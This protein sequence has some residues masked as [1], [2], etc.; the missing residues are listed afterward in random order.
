MNWERI[1]NLA[2]TDFGEQQDIFMHAI[3]SLVLKE[4]FIIHTENIVTKETT[5]NKKCRSYFNATKNISAVKLWSQWIHFFLSGLLEENQN[6][7][8]KERQ[9]SKYRRQPTSTIR[10]CISPTWKVISEATKGKGTAGNQ[11]IRLISYRKCQL[12]EHDDIECPCRKACNHSPWCDS[13]CRKNKRQSDVSMIHSI[14]IFTINGR[15]GYMKSKVMCSKLL[16][17]VGISP[18]LCH[19]LPNFLSYNL[20]LLE[21]D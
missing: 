2:R 19:S 15:T 20:R 3:H 17:Y 6:I 16:P 9:R 12:N 1:A 21:K 7:C 5:H 8:R 11:T 13:H 10:K 4:H 18:D 14:K